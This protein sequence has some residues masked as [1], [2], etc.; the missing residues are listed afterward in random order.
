MEKKNKHRV[1]VSAVLLLTTGILCAVSMTVYSAGNGELDPAF[2]NILTY[3]FGESREP[4][5]AVADIIRKSY[6]NTRERLRLEK[7]CAAILESNAT[8]ECKDFICRQLYII[9]TKESMPAL[10]KMLTEE[11]TSD[12]ARYA[13]QQNTHP[14]AGKAFRKALKNTTGTTLIGIINSLGERRDEKSVGA[15]GKY[16]SHTDENVATA[17]VSALGKIGGD[18]AKKALYKARK[19]GSQTIHNAASLALLVY[20]DTLMR[21]GRKGEAAGIYRS[22]C[23]IDEPK[24]VRRAALIGLEKYLF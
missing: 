5:A 2:K 18:K 13:L 14:D 21:Q 12:M 15:L 17:A 20:A 3:R 10:A 23:S 19:K 11:K 6:G 9:G 4:L 22:L 24:Q 8:Y 1:R 7:Q 16:I